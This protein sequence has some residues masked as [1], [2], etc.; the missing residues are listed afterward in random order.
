MAW[1]SGSSYRVYSNCV[2]K[3][4]FSI[5]QIVAI[6]DWPLEQGVIAIVGFCYGG[7]YFSLIEL[8]FRWLPWIETKYLLYRAHW[9]MFGT[10]HYGIL[11]CGL[12]YHHAYLIAGRWA[13]ASEASKK[14]RVVWQLG[15]YCV[16]YCEHFHR[17]SVSQLGKLSRQG[18][19]IPH[20]LV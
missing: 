14:P 6:N 20:W 4:Y 12:W 17:A 8:A 3:W 1:N 13:M 15:H 9:T 5:I 10:F 18:L 7:E 16:G 2:G 11:V 19:K